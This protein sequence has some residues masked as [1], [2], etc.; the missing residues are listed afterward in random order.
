MRMAMAI[1][2]R[3]PGTLDCDKDMD[4]LGGEGSSS[5]DGFHC[6]AFRHD[7]VATR[8]I[9]EYAGSWERADEEMMVQESSQWE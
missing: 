4:L 9:L 8:R 1:M 2:E 6:F 3:L 7:Q 5:L